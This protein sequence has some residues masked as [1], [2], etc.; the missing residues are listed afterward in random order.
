MVCSV[1]EPKYQS[2][3]SY[4]CY[5][6]FMSKTKVDI[7]IN[8]KVRSGDRSNIGPIGVVIY[9]LI[10]GA[11]E[12]EHKFISKQSM[13]VKRMYLQAGLKPAPLTVWVSTLTI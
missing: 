3:I 11:H 4:D 7:N 1:Q 10:L 13:T 9:S 12:F 2:C 8:A 6:K 5:R